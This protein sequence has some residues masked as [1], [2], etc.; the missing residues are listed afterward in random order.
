MHILPPCLWKQ[1]LST[2]QPITT[3]ILNTV[4][5]PNYT[6]RS[7]T[8]FSRSCIFNL[9]DDSS[10]FPLA[11][12]SLHCLTKLRRYSFSI[13]LSIS[14]PSNQSRLLLTTHYSLDPLVML[15]R[16]FHVNVL[17]HLQER[18]EFAT[19]L[20]WRSLIKHTLAHEY[21][22]QMRKRT[23]ELPFQL[24]FA[25]LF[26]HLMDALITGQEWCPWN[27]HVFEESLVPVFS[28]R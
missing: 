3:W 23:S 20:S 11:K 4:W 12:I 25:T 28:V 18:K 16:Y 8:F 5:C 21:L 19:D 6:S 24:T 26:Q 13:S 1:L 14:S 17:Y 22:V 7:F 2:I 27:V 10:S 9:K 15:S